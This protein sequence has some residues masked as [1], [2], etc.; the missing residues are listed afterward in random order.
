MTSSIAV[1][2]KGL[3]VLTGASSGIGAA[4]ARQLSSK[5]HPVL[6]VA[7]RA[8]RLE[9]LAAEIK[10]GAPIYPLAVDLTGPDAPAKILARADELGGAAWLVNDAGSNLFGPFAQAAPGANASMVRLNCEALVSLTQAMLPGM[11]ARKSGVLLNVSSVAG[12]VPTPYM[13]VYGATKAFVLSYTEALRQELLG[14]GIS[15]TAL[16]P[17]PVA[18]EIYALSAPGVPRKSPFNEITAEECAKAAIS[19]AE[20]GAA[21]AVPGLFNRLNVLSAKLAPR[22]LVR[23][24]LT[25]QGLSYLGYGRTTFKP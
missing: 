23:W 4:L 20:R 21:I 8:D 3:V 12:F 13:A 6:A 18:T 11:I 14:T 24:L 16:C 25:L 9:V 1:Q 17:G 22:A 15:V 19:A 5:G 2:R 10:E 7:R